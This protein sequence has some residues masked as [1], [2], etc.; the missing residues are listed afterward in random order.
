[1]LELKTINL[2]N[3]ISEEFNNYK[4]RN[5]VRAVI[6]DNENNIALMNVSKDNFHKLPGGGID[7]GET[8]I[9]ALKR[10]CLEEAGV[11]IEIISELGLISEIKKT[12]KTIQNSYCYTAKVI[13][14]KG[15][16]DFT[17][18]EKAKGFEIK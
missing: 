1:M 3:S 6:F 14:E 13:G 5:T 7:E 16:P 9:E 11:D 4:V 17:E 2:E 12:S 18:K 10:E 15:E 8:K